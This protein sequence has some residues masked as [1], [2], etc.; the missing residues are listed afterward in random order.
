MKKSLSFWEIT[1]LPHPQ[2]TK[3]VYDTDKNKGMN[4]NRARKGE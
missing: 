4:P 3:D 1:P 2:E